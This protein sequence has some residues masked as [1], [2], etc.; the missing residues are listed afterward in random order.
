MEPLDVPIAAWCLLG[1]VFAVMLVVD[2]ALHRGDQLDRRPRAIAWTV[3]WIGVAVAFGAGV[4]AYFGSD[5]GEQYFAAYLLEKSL[6]I[7]NLFVFMVVFAA[8]DIPAAQHRR[9]LTWGVLGAIVMRGAFIAVGLGVL[10]H[11]HAAVFVLGAVLVAMAFKLLRAPDRATVPRVVPW[12]ERHLPWTRTRHGNRFVV[13]EA[14]R[15]VATPLLVALIAVELADVLFAVDSL[16]GTFAITEE[17]FLVYS[18][19]LFAVLGLRSLYAV[20]GDLLA[21]L[22]YLHLG[23]AGVLAFA[24]AKML[25]SPWVTIAP[26]VSVGVIAAVLAA[27]AGASVVMGR[28]EQPRREPG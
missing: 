26:L 12:L 28:R 23:L 1:A 6:S 13:R 15:V 10:T 18:S 11:L 14:G 4:S 9:V 17:P 7:D 21:K 19:N 16:P 8:L 27:A 3:A 24:G 25:A 2:L 5:A 20:V 22:R